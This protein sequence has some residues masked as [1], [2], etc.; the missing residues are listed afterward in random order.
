MAES[1]RSLEGK[2]AIV[3]GA[4]RGLGREY[5]KRLAEVG[6]AVAI[7]DKLDCAAT[8]ADIEAVGGRGL[9]T[10]L[11]V[12]D[13]ASATNLAARALDAFGRIDILVN[14]AA[15]YANMES[16]P[17]DALDEAD[18]DACMTVNVKGTWNCCKAVVPAMRV[19]KGGSIIN[20]ASL[21]ATSGLP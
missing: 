2:T 13:M 4:A 8:L 5:A 1:E 6:A 15:L 19:Q 12:A 3:T 20:I 18:W 11:D 10:E 7:G 17:F 16:G 21:A 9:A 14:N